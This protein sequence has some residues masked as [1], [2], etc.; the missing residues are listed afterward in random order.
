[1]VN[2]MEVVEEEYINPGTRMCSGCS[3]SLIYRMALIFKGPY[4]GRGKQYAPYP[5]GIYEEY[6]HDPSSIF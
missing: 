2:V 3:M 4:K 5:E 6:L 1:M